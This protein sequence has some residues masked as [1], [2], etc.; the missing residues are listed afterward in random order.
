MRSLSHKN[1][2]K[3]NQFYLGAVYY[4]EHWS[5]EEFD[6]DIKLM[7][8]SNLNIVRMGEFA[9]DMFEKTE[10]VFDFNFFDQAI[11]KLNKAGIKTI[12]CTPTATPPRWLS[13]KYPQ[14]LR[15]NLNSEF[16]QHGSRQHACTNN[17]IFREYSR[18]ITTEIAKHF[19][20]NPA[21]ISFQTDN[22]L[23]CHFSFCYCDSCQKAFRQ[24]L[25]NKY[26]TIDKLNQA[27]GTA[28][29]AQ[30]YLDFDDIELP[31][32]GFPTYPNPSAMLDMRRFHALGV[33]EFQAEQIQ[34]LRSFNPDWIIFHNGMM[35]VVDYRG[36]FGKDL[37]ILG[38]DSYPF[39]TIDS[40]ERSW[41]N[42]YSLD[43]TR[44]L[45]GAFIIPEHQFGPGGQ[46]DYLHRTP[47][48]GEIQM[49][50]L[51]SIARGCESLLYFRWRSCRYGAEEYWC[52]I[53]D[54]D[55]IPRRRYNEF[56]EITK[57]MHKIAPKLRNAV[58]VVDV[59]VGAGDADAN[60]AHDIY[61][62]VE[63]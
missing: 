55:N 18:K 13:K 25:Q 36:K 5:S 2:P 4:P 58:S 20:K 30:S 42:A 8:E 51:R 47:E 34:I 33:A 37:D 57:N 29:W 50:T 24:F 54:W 7:R 19:Q 59:A 11:D 12:F 31:K 46:P 39:F 22:E 49:I 63:T 21:I 61:P 15:K 48:T 44:S 45:G 32:H 56:C 40:T 43:R 26:T 6:N 23:N 3:F 27:W 9:W 38:F 60:S 1:L 16:M 17:L 28:F 35:Q 62:L 53:I 14:I 41:K 52:G 10:G